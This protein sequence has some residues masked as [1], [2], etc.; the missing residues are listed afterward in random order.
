MAFNHM[1]KLL[2]VMQTF[3]KPIRI[4]KDRL[5]RLKTPYEYHKLR[6]G[7]IFCVR[8]GTSDTMILFD[9]FAEN[10]YQPKDLPQFK[11]QPN[12]LVLDFGANIGAFTLQAHQAGA[13][14]H[15]FEALPEN[16][17]LLQDNIYSNLAQHIVHL[18]QGAVTDKPG[19]VRM[20]RKAGSS[21][22]HWHEGESSVEV[23]SL[24]IKT[25]L[26]QFPHIDLLKC[27]I[28]GAEFAVFAALDAPTLRQFDR[29][30]MEYH[31]YGDFDHNQIIMQLKRAGFEVWDRPKGKNSLFGLLFAE[32][33]YIR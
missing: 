1:L 6:S 15:A 11:I 2:R 28:E 24:P 21:S 30:A 14:V 9:I 32:R 23:E 19:T 25:I 22:I 8:P 26:A 33:K 29:I 27:D 10:E 12:W 13:K 5:G 31:N 3:Q 4:L 16:Y 7:L 18:T 20:H 17:M